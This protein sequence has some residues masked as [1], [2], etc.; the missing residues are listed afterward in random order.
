MFVQRHLV[1]AWGSAEIE[2]NYMLAGSLSQCRVNIHRLK[3]SIRSPNHWA[4]LLGLNQILRSFIPVLL[5]QTLSIYIWTIFTLLSGCPFSCSHHF[6]F[7]V[8]ISRRLY[9]VWSTHVFI[10]QIFV[11]NLLHAKHCRY[12]LQIFQ[13]EC[14]KCNFLMCNIGKIKST[15]F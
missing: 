13:I 15:H 12:W 7:P 3:E 1:R 2:A 9:S 11:E 4:Q 10:E 14:F 8:H 5:E 6:F